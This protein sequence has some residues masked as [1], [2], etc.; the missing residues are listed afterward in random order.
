MLSWI[1]IKPL[2]QLKFD[3]IL[4]ILGILSFIAGILLSSRPVFIPPTKGI[5][6]KG[7]D[8]HDG[9]IHFAFYIGSFCISLPFFNFLYTL[10]SESYTN[11]Y[12]NFG[13]ITRF[14]DFSFSISFGDFL[15]FS[16]LCFSFLCFIQI[17][18]QGLIGILEKINKRKSLRPIYCE[19][20]KKELKLIKSAV[21]FLNEKEITAM[22]IKSIYFEAWYCQSCCTKIDRNSIHLRGYVSLSDIFKTC[23]H[24]GGLTMTVTSSEIIRKATTENEGQRLVVY[25]CRHCSHQDKKVEINPIDTEGDSG[26][27]E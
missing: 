6:I 5:Q 11:N 7:N 14:F 18:Y 9:I 21:D 12:P 1:S 20:C 8:E 23:S 27:F 3:Y 10:A 15:C 4:Y 25:T 16:F 26:G 24:C 17:I 22:R 2:L 19:K 13:M